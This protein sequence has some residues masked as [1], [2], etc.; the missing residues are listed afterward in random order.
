MEKLNINKTHNDFAEQELMILA[1]AQM[2]KGLF[3]SDLIAD[4][5]SHSLPKLKKEGLITVQLCLFDEDKVIRLTKKGIAWKRSHSG[6]LRKV[7]SK[8][9]RRAD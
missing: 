1:Q 6:I 3:E 7:Q 4:S 5:N 2:K 8:Y 9:K